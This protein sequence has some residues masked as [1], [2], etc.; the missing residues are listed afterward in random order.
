MR[1][2][3]MVVIPIP[4]PTNKTALFAVFLFSFTLRFFSI[5]STPPSYQILLSWF[6]KISPE[7][8]GGKRDNNVN[9]NDDDNNDTDTD[10]DN[11]YD[12]DNDN[13]DDTD[14]DN[15]NDNNS[16]NDNNNNNAD[17]GN[18]GNTKHLSDV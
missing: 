12:E 16:N 8:P 10:N 5:R 6:L 2:A 11:D 15:D 1:A 13:D 14:T 4:S 9:N 7:T 3:V 18:L 17:G